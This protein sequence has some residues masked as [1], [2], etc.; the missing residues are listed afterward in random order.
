MFN[1]NSSHLLSTFLF[2]VFTIFIFVTLLSVIF[3]SFFELAIVLCVLRYLFV[4]ISFISLTFFYQFYG[5]HLL[6]GCV[7]SICSVFE[8][9]H[10]NVKETDKN[11]NLQIKKNRNLIFVYQ[12]KR[13][14]QAKQEQQNK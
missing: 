14:R 1:P 13:M 2:L 6:S 12:R 4:A 3:I 7:F 8:C 5:V 9:R 11:N 10:N